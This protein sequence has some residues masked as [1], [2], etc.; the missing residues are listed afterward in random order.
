MRLCLP[1]P[2]FS[3]CG[4]SL[5]SHPETYKM[6]QSMIKK[7]SNNKITALITQELSQSVA[8]LQLAGAVRLQS[9]SALSGLEA[10]GSLLL[11]YGAD[12][13][14][15]MKNFPA[16]VVC[17]RNRRWRRA[18]WPVSSLLEFLIVLNSVLWKTSRHLS[19]CI[20]FLVTELHVFLHLQPC[21]DFMR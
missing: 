5:F 13:K 12:Q 15:N 4:E 18:V 7:P 19:F 11:H 20:K 2:S 16:A 17:S 3:F 10:C 21:Y 14:D 9:S 8:K 6:G 1:I